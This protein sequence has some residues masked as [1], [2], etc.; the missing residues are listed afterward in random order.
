MGKIKIEWDDKAEPR[1]YRYECSRG[2]DRV[3]FLAAL[4]EV[5]ELEEEEDAKKNQPTGA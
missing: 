4:R 2:V 1:Q 3:E 5:I